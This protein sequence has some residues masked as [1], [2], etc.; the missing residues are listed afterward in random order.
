MLYKQVRRA[1]I[2]AENAGAERRRRRRQTASAAGTA[3]PA[4][5]RER[6]Y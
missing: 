3:A 1:P 2:G 6:I 4:I 5:S